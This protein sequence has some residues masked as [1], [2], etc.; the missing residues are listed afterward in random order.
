[1]RK[2]M[3]GD[4]ENFASAG[5]TSQDGQTN[6]AVILIGARYCQVGKPQGEDS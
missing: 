1:M 2:K 3:M 6:H 4:V 5:T